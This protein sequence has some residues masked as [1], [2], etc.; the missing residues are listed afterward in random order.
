MGNTCKP[1]AVSFQCMTKFTTNKQKKKKKHRN[2]GLI[3][4]SERST[5]VGNGK[6]LQYSSQEN[7]MERGVWWPTVHEAAKSLTRLSTHTQNIPQRAEKQCKDLDKLM[8][9]GQLNYRSASTKD[10]DPWQK[11]HFL[12]CGERDFRK[13]IP[14]NKSKP[15]INYSLHRLGSHSNCLNTCNCVRGKSDS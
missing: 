3:P 11:T 5:G 9:S 10:S 13:D 8:E 12:F 15:D 6:P 2:A 1:M 7:S 14:M 4:R